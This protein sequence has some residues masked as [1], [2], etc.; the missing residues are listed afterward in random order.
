MQKQISNEDAIEIEKFIENL[1]KKHASP[2]GK[3]PL[4]DNHREQLATRLYKIAI[5]AINRHNPEKAPLMPFVK[6]MV[7]Q[8][9]PRE[10]AREMNAQIKLGEKSWELKSLDE[11]ITEDGGEYQ[12]LIAEDV[13]IVMRRSVRFAVREV[14]AKLPW[15]EQL[16]L[17]SLMYKD[18][19]AEA[20][21][22][23]LGVCRQ[24]FLT[25]RDEVAVPDFVAH[26]G[27]FK[28]LDTRVSNGGLSEM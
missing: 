19:T 9:A 15:Q 13:E 25:F 18:R 7:K 17:G 16:A 14:L 1:A 20:C 5:G 28:N 10:A 22:A 8:S 11:P 6:A 3:T 24:T 23:Q 2:E 27:E 12:D 21:A 26:W 4:N